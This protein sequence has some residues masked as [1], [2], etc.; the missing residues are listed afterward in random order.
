MAASSSFTEDLKA[1][2]TCAI[3]NDIFTDPRTLPCLHT[4][5][6]NCIKGWNEACQIERKRLRCPTC[7]AVVKIEG[8]DISKLPSSFTYNSLLQLFNVMKTKTDE[9]SQQQLPECVG[10][11]KRSVLVGFCPQCEG[12]I[13]NECIDQHKT[14]KPL[15]KTHQATLW[16]EFKTQ[17]VNS[18]INNQTICKEKYHQKCRLDYYCITCKKCICQKCG[19]TAHSSHDKVS[20]EEAAEDAKNL[21]RKEKDRLNELLLGYK[22]ELKLSNENMTRIQSEVDTAKAKVRNDTQALMKILQDRQNA[23]IATLDG[24][25]AEQTTANEDE[26]KDINA[27]IQQVTELKHQCKTTEEKNL[28][29]FILESYESLLDVCKATAQNKSILS[30][31]P[32]EQNTSIHFIPNTEAAPMMQKFKLGEV[33]ESVTDASRCSMESVSNVRCGFINEFVIVTRNSQG[34]ICHTNKDILDVQIQE[35]DGNNVQK[36]LTETETGRFLVTYKA[37]KPSPYKVLVSIGGKRI[38]NSPKNIETIDAKAEF[39]PSKIIDVKQRMSNPITLDVSDSGDIALVNND[40]NND[41]RVVL[42][43]ADGEYLRD[44]GGA[45][46]GEGQLSHPFG[47]IFN[48]DKLV[49]TDNPGSYGCIRVFDIDGTYKR[50]LCKLSSGMILKRMCAAN[51]TIACLCYD[52]NITET[53]IKVFD[54]DSYDHLHDIKLDDPAN[55]RM[56][57]FSLV[58]DNNKYFVSFFKRSTVRVFDEKGSLLYTFGME[59]NKEG[60]FND[61]RGLAVFGKEMLFVCDLNNH[62]VQVFSQE[63]QFI[64]S[65]GSYGSG[66]GQMNR[67]YDVAVTPDGRVFVLERWAQRVQVWR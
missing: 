48:K 53:F 27:N 11:S 26:K 5:C 20:I 50:T 62:R 22:K 35:V 14:V 59:G 54:K 28:E 47:V 33:V 58:Y 1:Q 6:F 37:E 16:S 36:E 31:K 55:R 51:Q 18:Y 13:C 3:C 67:P 57:P 52:Q 12:I 40:F 10:C 4:F 45:G 23:L 41:F 24:L 15:I 25:L 38:K 34:D 60:Q 19:T 32:V 21:I 63:G 42:F 2:L 43:N 30:T 17:N 8:D 29:K 44:I 39:Q 66:L 56:H 64:T 61:V 9:H 49:I 65:F 46:S 7:R